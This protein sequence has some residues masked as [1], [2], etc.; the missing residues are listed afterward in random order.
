M[1]AQFPI[2]LTNAIATARFCAGNPI[3]LG[4]CLLVCVRRIDGVAYPDE[5]EGACGVDTAKTE[6]DE[7]VLNH[8]VGRSDTDDEAYGTE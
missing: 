4:T 7:Y 3:T 1:E 8:V 6:D 2:P 5:N